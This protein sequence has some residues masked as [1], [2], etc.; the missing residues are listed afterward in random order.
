VAVAV[1]LHGIGWGLPEVY[2]EARPLKTA[3]QMW[4]WGPDESLDLNPHFFNY[5]SLSI[6]SQFAGQAAL[7]AGMRTAHAVQSTEEFRVR[8]HSEPTPFYV[9]GRLINV[10]FGALTI[11]FLYRLARHCGLEER[12]GPVR[13][14]GPATAWIAALL[15][16]VNPFHISR[17][18]MIEVDVPMTF[19]AVLSIAFLVALVDAPSRRRYVLAGMTAGLAAATKY[20]GALLLP[21]IVAACLVAR[22]PSGGRAFDRRGLLLAGV[23]FAAAFVSASPFV[24]A[25]SAA[26]WS[27]F[28]AEQSHMRLGHFGVG[29]QPAWWY[30][31]NALANRLAG[32]PVLVLAAVGLV[33]SLAIR[34][35]AWSVVVVSFV[36]PYALAISSW[37]MMADRYAL[38]LLP[39]LFLY[40]AVGLL[41]VVSF[42]PDRPG[43]RPA[44][45]ATAVA[46]LAAPVALALPGH[47]E[48][49]GQDS[50]TQCVDWI[51]RN[52]PAGSFVVSEAYGPPLQGPVRY[53][54]WP[55]DIRDRIF[56]AVTEGEKPFLSNFEIPMFQVEWDQSA[57]FYDIR[58]YEEADLLVTTGAVR[59]RYSR[60][61]DRFRSQ[62]E[63]YKQLDVVFDEAARFDPSGT[64]P[65]IVVYRRKTARP[66][67]SRRPVGPLPELRPRGA[68]RP[69]WYGSYYYRMAVNYEAWNH[70]ARAIAGYEKAMPFTKGDSEVYREVVYGMIR[71]LTLTGERERALEFIERVKA[72]APTTDDLRF[73]EQLQSGLTRYQR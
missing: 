42:V 13:R 14:I 48:R 10:F 40:A 5:P 31:S 46:A 34:R 51:E 29:V 64:G 70:M 17:T 68:L 24:V 61:P 56:T 43:W 45:V 21:A 62:V 18:Q 52:V 63:F 12:S 38:P 2:E 9:L 27:D 16:T 36:V 71:C 39:F 8:Y 6:Y 15:L 72:R 25:D 26:F 58:L 19:F 3:W 41:A 53:W 57:A 22:R 59:S 23:S 55:G 66:P 60:D 7:Y 65:S 49:Y 47:F 69:H 11:L 28:T 44:A 37:A 20:T 35:Q 54:Q 1:R 33:Y 50:R 32:W 4:G 67:F 30:Y 73:V